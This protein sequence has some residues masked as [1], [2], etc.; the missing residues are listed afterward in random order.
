MEDIPCQSAAIIDTV[1]ELR[2]RKAPLGKG[3]LQ[4]YGEDTVRLLIGL[5]E[6]LNSNIS[7]VDPIID[8]VHRM[9]NEEIREKKMAACDENDLP[10]KKKQRKG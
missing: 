2:G 9:R 7:I 5:S 8:K 6:S 4:V 1:Q 3:L 10:P